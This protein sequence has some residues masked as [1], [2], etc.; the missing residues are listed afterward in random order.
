MAVTT[1]ASLFKARRSASAAAKDGPE[2]QADDEVTSRG[3]VA[4]PRSCDM[5]TYGE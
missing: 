3:P 1:A 2:E 4:N 5:P